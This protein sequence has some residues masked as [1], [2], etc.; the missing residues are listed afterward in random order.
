MQRD[1]VTREHVDK[2]LA[3]Q[4]TREAGLAVA[5]WHN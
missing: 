4:A 3:A 1:D 5:S 2:I